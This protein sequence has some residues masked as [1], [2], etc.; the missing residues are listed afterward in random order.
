MAGA[1]IIVLVLLALPVIVLMSG[2]V[3][4]AILGQMLTRDGNRRHEGSEL[5]TLDD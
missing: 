2:G 3:A 1:I 4:S 5:V